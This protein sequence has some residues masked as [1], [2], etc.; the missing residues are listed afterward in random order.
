M[1][2]AYC[3]ENHI[4]QE[5][6]LD[7]VSYTPDAMVLWNGK[8]MQEIEVP[9]VTL[10]P[11]HMEAGSGFSGAHP[12]RISARNPHADYRRNDRQR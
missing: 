3:A 10:I 4:T 11:E 8:R 7:E 2:L 1:F 9:R 5:V 12:K 6:I